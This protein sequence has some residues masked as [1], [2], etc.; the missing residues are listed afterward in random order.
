MFNE[1]NTVEQLVLDTICKGMGWHFVPAD[2]LPRQYSDVLV[3][4]MV[5]DALIRL[6]P[7]IMAQPDAD[8]C[9]KNHDGSGVAA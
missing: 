9:V 1:E 3:E 8:S 7:S 2:D 6:N 4:T 5:R